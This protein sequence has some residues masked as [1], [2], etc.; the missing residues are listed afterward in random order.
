MN[1]AVPQDSLKN[2]PG[3]GIPA[4]RRLPPGT[5]KIPSFAAVLALFLVLALALGIAALAWHLTVKIRAQERAEMVEEIRTIASLKVRELEKWLEDKLIYTAEPPSGLVAT[6]F[7][8]WLANGARHD[9]DEAALLAR[10]EIMKEMSSEHREVWLAQ[11]DGTPPADLSPVGYPPRADIRSLHHHPEAVRRAIET[12]KTVLMD[13]HHDIPATERPDI[14]FITPLLIN[15]GRGERVIGLLYCEIDPRWYLYPLIQT[16]PT[17]GKTGETLL[18]RGEGSDVVYLNELR[19]RHDTALKLRMPLSTPELLAAQ[20]ARGATGTLSGKDYMDIPAVGVVSRIRGT[21]WYLISKMHESEIDDRVFEQTEWL[22]IAAAVT[23]L[24]LGAILFLG[25]RQASAQRSTLLL[26]A[27]MERQALERHFDYL[28]KYANDIIL[29][30]TADG[31]LI[32]ANDAALRAYGYTKEELL[33]LNIRDLRAPETLQLLGQH[34]RE[35]KSPGGALF[36]TVHRRKDGSTFPVEVSTR[37]INYEGG[38]VRQSV[39]RDTSEREQAEAALQS[40]VQFL[41]ALIDSIPSPIFY[42]D[43]KARYLGCNTAF[44]EAVGLT[45]AQVLGKT[46]RDIWPVDLAQVYQ[47]ADAELLR[48]GGTQVLTSVLAFPTGE[49]RDVLF[50]KALFRNPDGTVGGLV[51]SAIDITEKVRAEKA[52]RESEERF[53]SLV[54]RAPEAI[55]VGDLRGRFAYVNP[56]ALKL[57]GATAPEQLLGQ[58]AME[59]IHPDFRAVVQERMR[60]ISE[61]SKDLSAM[62]E[63]FLRLDGAAVDVEVAVVPITYENQPGGLVFVRDITERKQT[64]LEYKTVLQTALDAYGAA[65]AVGGRFVEVNDALCAML[66]YSREE[67]LGMSVSDIEAAE[68]PDEVAAHIQNIVRTGFDRFETQLR[69]K[70]GDIL[71]VD[72]SVRYLDLKGGMIFTFM[73]DITEAKR[74]HIHLR[75]LNRTLRLLSECN[76]ALVRAQDEASLLGDICRILAEHGGYPLVWAGAV[77]PP[78]D[79]LVRPLAW[80]GS[81][82]GYLE[83]LRITWDEAQEGRGPTGTAVRQG[84]RA[85]IPDFTADRRCGP[86]R[87]EAERYKLRSAISLPLM[88][89]GRVFAVLEIYSE[90]RETFE[91]AEELR[92]LDELAADLAYGMISCRVEIERKQAVADRERSILMIRDSLEDAILAIANTVE[93][94]DAYTAGHQRRVANLAAAIAREIGFGEEQVRGIHLAGVVHDIGKIQVPVEILAKPTRLSDIEYEIIKTHAQA[95]Y[96]ILK[97]IEFPWPVANIVHQHHERLDGSGYPRGLKGEEILFD[98][99]IV[100]VADVVEAMASDRPYRPGLGIEAA[101]AEIERGAGRFYDPALVATCVRLFRQQGYAFRD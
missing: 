34:L 14:G 27:C 101:L 60:Q 51:G 91:D 58:P 23:V 68:M 64:A 77:E 52:L 93:L 95:G 80:A 88:S 75:R 4:A 92:L 24:A 48:H 44:E 39:I 49:R 63:K 85:I 20:A 15:S 89:H 28:A 74:Q 50:N 29:L 11:T 76:E 62:E 33:R 86:W 87:S 94:R 98:A 55:Y 47:R 81:A 82:A 5:G 2:P 79:C 42:K 35:G 22:Q 78:P 36:A 37:L 71:E 21:P 7:E 43:T 61:G 96:E 32:E 100:A 26:Q 73:R 45:R 13:F 16:W 69:R 6:T 70:D 90:L 1:R 99:R 41:Q 3:L 72:V 38:Q 83:G 46:A 31:D 8:R 30:M 66:G 53:R 97:D 65:T 57:F 19:H 17:A 10:L 9:T 84:Q 18:F 54:E 25:W 59:R 56:A 12:H 40:Q 67:L